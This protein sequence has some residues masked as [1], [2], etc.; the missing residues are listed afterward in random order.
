MTR[1]GSRLGRLEAAGGGSTDPRTVEFEAWLS[2]PVLPGVLLDFAEDRAHRRV[3]G[4]RGLTERDGWW[5]WY[6]LAEEEREAL[7]RREVDGLAQHE[8][9]LG[10]DAGWAAWLAEA[11]GWPGLSWT[12]DGAAFGRRYAHELAVLATHR[13]F[14]QRAAWRRRTGWRDGMTR[15]EEVAFDRRLLAERAERSAGR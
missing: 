5:H 8:R 2:T 6:G 4:E 7:A 10:E 3:L 15:E 14:P 12:T 11:D 13:R 1:L 9:V